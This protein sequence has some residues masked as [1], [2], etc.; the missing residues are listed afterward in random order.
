MIAKRASLLPLLALIGCLSLVFHPAFAAEEHVQPNARASSFGLYQ[1]YSEARY[2][3]YERHSVYVPMRDGVRLAVDYFIPTKNGVPAQEKLPVVFNV[4]HYN[5]A[6]SDKNGNITWHALEDFAGNGGPLGSESWR[7]ISSHGYVMAFA[8]VRGT[9]ASFGESA[10]LTSAED[11][12]DGY[13]LIAW[14]AK[15]PWSNGKIGMYG[16]SYSGQIQYL[17]ASEKPPALSALFPVHAIF[18]TYNAIAPGGVVVELYK[19]YMAW[20]DELAGEGDTRDEYGDNVRRQREAYFGLPTPVEGPEG[21]AALADILAA[22]AENSGSD[23]LM[24]FL[25]LVMKARLMPSLNQRTESGMQNFAMRLPDITEANIPAYH[26][27]GLW[28]NNLDATLLWYGN[29]SAP[30]KIAIGPWTHGSDEEGD[31]RGREDKPLRTIEAL[32]WFD[33][34]L[35]GIDNGVTEGDVLNIAVQ[36]AGYY[37]ARDVRSGYQLGEWEW[38]SYPAFPIPGTQRISFA[39]T[40]GKS[41]TIDSVNDGRL[42]KGVSSISGADAFKVDP[43]T[44]LGPTNRRFDSGAFG[45]LALPNMRDNDRKSLTYTTDVLEQDVVVIGWPVLKLYAQSDESDGAIFAWLEEVDA[46]GY[47]SLIA[48]GVLKASHRTLGEPP[49]NNFG[50]PWPTSHWQD[51]FFSS[52]FSRDVRTLHFPLYPTA[53][54]F[55]AGKRIRLTIAGADAQNMQLVEPEAEITVH[56]GGEYPSQLILPVVD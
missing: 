17:I 23:F 19:A 36:S 3:G 55:K 20:V 40:G 21:Q 56:Y 50:N 4:T 27:G 31:P 53:T 25:P 6:W 35:K 43:T 38:R 51:V 33:H 18:D 26:W 5:R 54:R 28:D 8:D 10:G 15:Q 24:R 14:L 9:G 37:S 44:S 32:R 11:A 12:R 1:G 45:P 34:W 46:D 48:D 49:Y 13:D 39:L 52:S 2:D 47:S 42:I 29:W 30:Q 7:K 16:S 22:R 41:E